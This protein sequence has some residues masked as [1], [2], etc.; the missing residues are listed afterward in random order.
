MRERRAQATGYLEP[1]MKDSILPKMMTLLIFIAF[2]RFCK[3]SKFFCRILH[4]FDFSRSVICWHEPVTPFMMQLHL[5]LK[6]WILMVPP[7]SLNMWLDWKPLATES[8]NQSLSF[9]TGLL[10]KLWKPLTLS[11]PGKE[12]QL[13]FDRLF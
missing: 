1:H 6:K 11:F 9:Q 8:S 10:W 4:S 2:L 7:K 5:L 13:N 12:L 3:T